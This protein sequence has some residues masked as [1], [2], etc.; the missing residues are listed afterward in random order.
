M[1]NKWSVTLLAAMVVLAGCKSEQKP[2]EEIRPVR[3]MVVGGAL[4]A[5]A[6]V[7]SGEVKAQHEVPLGFRIPGKIISRSVSV[8]DMV[9]KGQV[10]AQLDAGDVA[11]N[12]T[13]ARAALS[14]AQ[15]QL[16]QAKLD[17]QRS[18]DLHAQ[19]FVSQ[20]EVDKRQTALISAQ[21]L[22]EQA[23]A[24]VDLANNQASYTQLTADG[25]GVITQTL[26]E[27]GAVVSA[28]QSVLML[29]KAGQYEAVIDVPENRVQA[30][31]PGQKVA[32]QLWADANRELVGTVSEVAPAAD[33]KTRTFRVKVALPEKNSA[34]LGMTIQVSQVFASKEIPNE[35]SVPMSAIFGKEQMMRVWLVDAKNTVHSQA[36]TVL[37]HQ[38]QQ[39]RIQGIPAKSVVVTAGVHLLR[40]GQKIKILPAAQGAQQ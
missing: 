29:A 38:G 34:A 30:W 16:A 11:L 39:V 19:N 15:A 12:A 36:I 6:E 18:Q 28:G 14:S 8:G 10:L 25:D 4:P 7:Y 9:K 40:E 13:A 27:P 32:V 2:V 22:T 31:Q 21:K 3:T 33:S 5:A 17:Y 1:L 26:A 20:A 24:Q 35:I 37:G 23:K